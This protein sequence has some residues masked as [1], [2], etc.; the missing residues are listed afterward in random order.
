MTDSYIEISFGARDTLKIYSHEF[1]KPFNADSLPDWTRISELRCPGN[2]KHGKQTEYCTLSI[3]IAK[4]VNYFSDISS[5]QYGSLKIKLENDLEINFH[6][7]AQSIF[8]NATWFIL[9]LSNC[10]V[11]K[12]SQWARSNYL[13]SSNPDKLF[14]I[15]FSIFLTEDYALHPDKP[16]KIEAL[17]AQLDLLIKVLN[18][19]LERIR[20]NYKSDAKS[21]AVNNGLVH[22]SNLLLLLEVDFE[23]RLKQLNQNINKENSLKKWV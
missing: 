11:F 15:L 2:V 16:P 14:Y 6:T 10:S 8:F 20:I 18:T 4:L 22:F 3:E 9:I 7:D 1:I 13:P 21:D 19:L 5:I 17:Q 12:N 23:E